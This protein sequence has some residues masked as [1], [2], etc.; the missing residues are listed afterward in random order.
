MTKRKQF[1]SSKEMSQIL[2]PLASVLILYIPLDLPAKN[3][4][5]AEALRNALLTA[6]GAL[7]NMV[8][9]DDRTWDTER[10]AIHE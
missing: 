5:E 2:Q 1:Y 7:N 9:M 3:E 10:V 6:M 4:R 8:D